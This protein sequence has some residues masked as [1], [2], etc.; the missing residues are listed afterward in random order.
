MRMT[1]WREDPPMLK[2]MGKSDMAD[3]LLKWVGVCGAI[4][5]S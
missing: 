1:S 2:M 5:L 3:M 4:I